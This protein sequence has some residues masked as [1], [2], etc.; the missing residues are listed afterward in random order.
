VL[1]PTIRVEPFAG[2]RR[3]EVLV[4]WFGQ[5]HGE[6]VGTWQFRFP[7]GVPVDD[8]H[9]MGRPE[10]FQVIFLGAAK[11]WPEPSAVPGVID[12][13]GKGDPEQCI[14]WLTSPHYGTRAESGDGPACFALPLRVSLADGIYGI[15]APKTYADLA[16]LE[17]VKAEYAQ[18]SRRRH[19]R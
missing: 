1:V 2:G 11:H 13:L 18:L 16:V 6:P 14:L 9:W 12:G 8:M 3:E 17:R 5:S 7:V 19:E 10:N 4:Q 15:I